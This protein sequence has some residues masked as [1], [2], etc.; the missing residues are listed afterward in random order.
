MVP[1]QQAVMSDPGGRGGRG[2]GGS[3]EEN[4]RGRPEDQEVSEGASGEKRWGPRVH[5]RSAQT[6]LWDK[7]HRGDAQKLDAASPSNGS[8]GSALPG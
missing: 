6:D 5:I 4:L 3:H 2:L 8:S 7:H 1:F